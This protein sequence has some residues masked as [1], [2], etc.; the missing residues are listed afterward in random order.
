MIIT[1]S[2]RTDIPAYY[3]RWFFNRIKEGYVLVRNPYHPELINRYEL[4]ADVVDCLLFCT[5]NPIPMLSRLDEISQFNQYWYVTITA[6]GKDIEPNVPDK[7]YVIEAFK[8]LSLRYGPKAVCWRYDP[9][10]Y[11][12][13]Y[14]HERHVKAFKKIAEELDGYTNA[15]GMSFMDLY[16]KTIRN[17]PLLRRPSEQEQ[18]ALLKELVPI[19]KSHGMV[20]RFCTKNQHL[21]ETGVDLQGCQTQDVFYEAIGWKLLTKPGPNCPCLMGRDIGVYNSCPHLCKYCY[22][23]YSKEEV[24]K[25]FAAHDPNSPLLIGQLGPD[26][27]IIQGKQKQERDFKVSLF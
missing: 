10:A 25:S 22:A 2:M 17:A 24:A 5:K 18:I 13:G 19:A 23:N 16:E 14:D 9:I 6:Y 15:I 21:A 8:K 7:R 1:T 20:I 26:E 11:G 12:M 4:N 27:K 3:S